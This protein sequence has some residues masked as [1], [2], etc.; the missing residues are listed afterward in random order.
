MLMQLR[1]VSLP[2][3]TMGLRS[4][5]KISPIRGRT[6]KEYE[7]QLSQ[8]KKEN[9]NLKLRIYFLE[10][11]MGHISLTDDKEDPFKRNIE[12]KV[13]CGFS[14]RV[15]VCAASVTAKSVKEH[16]ELLY[17]YGAVLPALGF[18]FLKNIMAGKM[19]AYGKLGFWE[20]LLSFKAQVG[21]VYVI[22]CVGNVLILKLC[23]SV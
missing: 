7:E 8:L 17:K 14:L 15:F 4:P 21:P 3:V 11:R 9:F 13:M 1:V 5:G 10:E 23:S 12:L 18:A 2:I 22:T 6:M 20:L 19:K 16:K